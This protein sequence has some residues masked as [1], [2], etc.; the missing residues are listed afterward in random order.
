MYEVVTVKAG[1]DLA[2]EALKAVGRKRIF[3]GWER[4]LKAEQ[5][6][7]LGEY[8]KGQKLEGELSIVKSFTTPRPDTTAELHQGSGV[9]RH[10]AGLPRMQP[11]RIRCSSAGT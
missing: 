7:P 9:K 5:P 6:K 4:F 3:D 11:Y 8:R 2:P 10:R 1:N